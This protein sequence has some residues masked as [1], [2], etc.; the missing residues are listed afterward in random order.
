MTNLGF[1]LMLFLWNVNVVYCAFLKQLTLSNWTLYNGNGSFT[2]QVTL[3]GTTHTHLMDAGLIS[4][5]HYRYSE[6]ELSWI[7]LD[8]WS[9]KAFFEAPKQRNIVLR[10]ETIDGPATIYLNDKKI[11]NTVNSFLSYEF[12]LTNL[13]HDGTNMIRFEFEPPLAYAAKEASAYPYYVPATINPN[14]WAEPTNRPFIRKSGSD[15]GWDWGPAFVTVGLPLGV[16][17]LSLEPLCDVQFDDY[18]IDQ[19]LSSDCKLAW[20]TFHAYIHGHCQETLRL[21]ATVNGN[22]VTSSQFKANNST[23]IKLKYTMKE[24][25]LWWPHGHG[26]PHLYDLMFTLSTSS[27][28]ILGKKHGKFGVRSIKLIQK[29]MSPEG[30]SFG[31]EVNGVPIFIRGSNWIPSNSFPTRVTKN[32]LSYLLSSSTAANM[33]MIRVWGGGR[34]ESP[35]FYELCDELG[36]LV[37]QEFMFACASYPRHESFLSTVSAEVVYQVRRLA[38]Y[39]SI[40]IWGGNNENESIM[41]QFATGSFIPPE[42][43]F[44]RDRAVVDYVKV[45]IDT[46]QPLVSAIDNSRPFVDTSPSNGLLSTTPYVKRWENTSSIYYGDV[47]YYNVKED[48]MNWSQYPPAR[49]ISEF[50]FQSLPSVISWLQVSSP[51]DWNS[52]NN[53]TAFMEYRQRSP[54]GTQHIQHQLDLHFQPLPLYS[55]VFKQV[56]AFTWLTQIQ[57]GLCYNTAIETWRRQGVQGVLYWQLNDIWEGPSWSSIEFNGKWKALHSMVKRTFAPTLAIIHEENNTKLIVTMLSDYDETINLRIELRHIALGALVADTTLISIVVG[58]HVPQIAWCKLDIDK[59]L[60]AH[61]CTRTSCFLVVDHSSYHFFAPFKALP[62]IPSKVTA[63]VIQSNLIVWTIQVFAQDNFAMF[64]TLDAP[65]V[66]GQW[67]DNVFHL[68]PNM[69]HT[70]YFFP[71]VPQASQQ[72][73]FTYLQ[74]LYSGQNEVVSIN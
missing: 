47:H 18:S 7:A 43:E 14:T 64:V 4:N 70:V 69:N 63:S 37:W 57:Q 72:I 54:N 17:L 74:E 52:Y 32:H 51:S 66:V 29:P 34:Y 27:G 40:V 26:S 19:D 36:L 28:Q 6:R 21:D 9:Y 13:L 46:I 58:K 38:K 62:M 16:Q 65:G 67:S 22:P 53:I 50:G 12:I 3:P 39:T 8:T 20:I 24:P 49:F 10:C 33:N 48:C 42:F 1:S 55:T 30:K 59:Y 73:S 71:K 5:L 60:N 68:L 44:N 45:F 2:L 41:D 61:R 31:F 25:T 15:F 35:D 11:A 23:H 56:H